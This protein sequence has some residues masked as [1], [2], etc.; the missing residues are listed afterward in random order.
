MT[1]GGITNIVPEI[2]IAVGCE[3][4][5]SWSK[6]QADRW[7]SASQGIKVTSLIARSFP[8]LDLFALT[9]RECASARLVSNWNAFTLYLGNS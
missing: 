3:S 5:E 2:E 4:G 9:L 6:N 1:H 8:F 7:V